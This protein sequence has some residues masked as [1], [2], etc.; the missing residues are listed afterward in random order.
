MNKQYILFDLDGTITN[1]AEGIIN[2]VR[3]ALQKMK[4]QE[5]SLKVLHR[6]IGPPLVDA[7]M[8][9]CGMDKVEAEKAVANYRERYKDIGVFECSLYD[10][11]EGVLKTLKYANKTI[12]LA[13]AKPLVFAKKVIEHFSLSQY[14]SDLVG[15]EIGGTL[16]HK[17]QII[18]E[19]IK[20]FNITDRSKAI[21]VGDREQDISGAKMFSLDSIGVKYGFAEPNELEDAGATYIAETPSDILKILL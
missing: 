1:S 11:I 13:T 18:D 14:F 9:Y 21:M 7:F 10:E 2:C 3:Y 20:R 19:V 12:I 4:W 6:F 8:D 17:H 15:A 16:L 5:P